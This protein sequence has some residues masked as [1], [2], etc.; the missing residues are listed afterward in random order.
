MSYFSYRLGTLANV[1][2]T[3]WQ[4]TLL[5]GGIESSLLD[6]CMI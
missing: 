1:G 2:V 5:G 4:Q 3:F 6:T